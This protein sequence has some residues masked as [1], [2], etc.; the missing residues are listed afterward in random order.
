MTASLRLL[1]RSSFLLCVLVLLVLGLILAWFA[2]WRADRL[3]ALDSASEITK[4]DLGPV[5]FLSRGE[6][7]AVLVFHGAPGGYDQAMLL[8][9]SLRGGRISD[10]CAVASRLFAHAVG[11]RDFC[12]NS[13]LTLWQL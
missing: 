1:A 13:K 12:P 3:A 8:G 5:E 2:S 7:P 9:S 11:H 10:R 4:T 6:G